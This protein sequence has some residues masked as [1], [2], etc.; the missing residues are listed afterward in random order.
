MKMSLNNKII[1]IVLKNIPPN[2]KPVAYLATT[3]TISRESSYRRIRGDI[4]FSMNEMVILA[5]KLNFSIDSV[6]EENSPDRAYFDFYSI[7][8]NP[9]KVF[10]LMMEK[11]NDLLENMIGSDEAE[12]VVALN[13]L[14]PTF[15]ALY[16][17]LFKFTFYKWLNQSDGVLFNLNFADVVLSNELIVLQKKIKMNIRKMGNCILLLDPN[18]VLCLVK[19]IQYY[20]LKRLISNDDLLSLKE[21]LKEMVDSFENI[22]RTG[23]FESGSQISL[24]LSSLHINANTGYFHYGDTTETHIWVFTVDPIVV[25]NKE[26]SEKQKIWLNSLKRQ[27]TLISQSNEILQAEFFDQQ[28]SYIESLVAF[29]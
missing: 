25:Y 11:S 16:D 17:N 15:M 29:S 9:V 18:V 24:Y 8:I 6:I 26:V 19:D 1:E 12:S 3:L 5:S 13:S 27:S 22:A 20:Y 10:S 14:P 21:N 2:I 28:R 23:L 7:N 4:P